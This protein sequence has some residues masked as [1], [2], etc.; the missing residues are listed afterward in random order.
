MKQTLTRNLSHQYGKRTKKIPPVITVVGGL[1]KDGG[2]LGEIERKKPGVGERVA[3]VVLTFAHQ[4][5]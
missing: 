4:M 3:T 2:D 1:I 5:A